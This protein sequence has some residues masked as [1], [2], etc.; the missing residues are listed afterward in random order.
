[1]KQIAYFS[2]EYS[3][4][5]SLPI[6]AGG[7][8]I[9]AGDIVQEAGAEGRNF[10]AYGMVYHQSFTSGDPDT[11]TM[12][13]RL[14]AEGFAIIGGE[15]G[16]AREIEVTVEDQPVKVVAWRK[17]FGTA[18]LT[19]LDTNVHGNPG[20]IRQI[21]DH[22]Y[23]GRPGMMLRQ[24]IVLGLGATALMAVEG[25]APDVYHLNEGHM[26]FVGIAA[27]LRY[28][29]AHKGMTLADAFDALR[30]MIAATK[31]TILAGA[32]L[33]LEPAVLR[34]ALG[35]N[36]SDP[37]ADMAA[38]MALGGKPDGN[39]STTR[40][41]LGLA[42][43]HSGVSM[44]HV[45]TEAV[46]HPGSPLKATT[47]GVY[48]ARWRAAELTG[49]QS[50]DQLRAIHN[51]N[52]HE[53]VEH[54]N[55]AT[56]QELAPNCLTI[57]W[58]RRMTAYKRPEL[59]VSDLRRLAALANDPDRPVRFIVAGKANPADPTGIGLMNQIIDAAKQANLSDHFAY[60]P[61]YN[62]A[63]AR[64]LVQGADVWLNT[65]I[66]GMEACGTS[67]M[68]ASLNGAL[69]LSVSDGWIDAID[70]D[71]IGWDLPEDAPIGTLY[72]ILEQQVAPLYYDQPDAWMAKM[73][74][75]INLIES[76]FTAD[77]MLARYDEI[78]YK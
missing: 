53:L 61:N 71:S 41:V 10:H 6:Y 8:G 34:E 66:R 65:P 25:V 20:T 2:A 14:E 64:L 5:D 15:N 74:A 29:R 50:D 16:K 23:D 32:G 68:K 57:V 44:I 60:L 45:R 21:T 22:L 13:Q 47:N 58:A 33:T 9:L 26:S 28:R 59:L 77:K 67:G 56:G 36:L 75:N 49:N 4:A 11:R 51:A 43:H 37:D 78:L 55:R 72:D 1:M 30:P 7:L 69:Q 24:Q 48:A 18:S 46:N 39:F 38:I 63:S 76:R 70:I 40:C 54:V 17:A 62:P 31:H 3:V 73:R 42:G 35:S 12:S 27:A 19:L 52:R